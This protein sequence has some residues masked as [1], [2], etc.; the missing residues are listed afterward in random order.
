MRK[1]ASLILIISGTALLITACGFFAYT[2]IYNYTAGRRAQELLE[3]MM[4][5]VD[6]RLPDMTEITNDAVSHP[7]DH[8]SRG[9]T[10]PGREPLVTVQV[11]GDAEPPDSNGSTLSG[12]APESGDNTEFPNTQSEQPAYP[13]I[14]ILSIPKLG[15]R[16]PVISESSDALLKISVCRLS[17]YV[18][19]KPYRLVVA[20]HNIKSHFGGLESL[21]LGDSV[22]FTTGAGD[23][24]YY[25][26]IEISD[27]RGTDGAHVLASD[28]WDITLLTCKTDN[29]M[30]TM[31]RFAEKKSREL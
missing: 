18:D 15:V 27:I 3:S 13:T 20:G 10:Y 11:P 25:S 22:A 7:N 2:R 1:K 12:E 21:Q 14:G 9:D 23:T 8:D 24:T 19:S 30:R 17:G 4:E 29:T 16:L 6:W 5:E 28:G 31:I 26:A